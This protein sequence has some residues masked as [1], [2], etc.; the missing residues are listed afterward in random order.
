MLKKIRIENLALVET[1]QI[2]FD[3]GLTV[4]TGETGAGKSI[5]VNALSLALGGR[6]EREYIR[7]GA[8]RCRVEADFDVSSM[9]AEFRGKFA[10][11]INE[12]LL[13]ISREITGDGR[14]RIRISDSPATLGQLKS[15]TS[16]IAE[17]LG[18]H[19][20]QMLMNEDNHLLFLDHFAALARKKEI[21][22]GAYHDWLQTATRLS[23]ITARR[24]QLGAERELLLFQRNEIEKAQIHVG[25]EEQLLS[26]RKVLDS[27]RV[28]MASADMIRDIIENEENS[29]SSLLSLA[30]KELDRMARIDTQL[31]KKVAEL[32]EMTYQLEDLRAF[33]EQYGSSIG[34]D[35]GR[36]EEINLRLDEIYNLKKKYGGSEQSVLDSLEIINK[37]LSETPADID[38]YIDELANK[39]RAL[40]ELYSRHA[41]TLSHARKKAATHLQKLVT[42]ELED[43]AIENGGFEFE[44]VYED[45]P[46]G[47]VING[48]AVRPTPDGL[49]KGRIMF[50]A[51]PGEPLK[52]LV[53][54][55][56]G[57]EISRVLLALK[58]AEK[59]NHKLLHSLLVFDEVDSGIGGRTAMKVGKKLAR[60][61]ADSQ[62][63]VITHLHQIARE[64]THHLLAEKKTGS[65]KRSVISVRRLDSTG[66]KQEL[67]RMMALPE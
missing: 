35:P 66:I 42:R 65:D 21:V 12:G 28:L 54:T 5:I 30:Q 34:D 22:A 20:A 8:D 51:N 39:S 44:F 33:I 53:K 61:S 29:V 18:Q 3:K 14:S 43:L 63:I 32:I 60:L 52:S 10:G 25:E 16:P 2:E 41:L 17:I 4:L 57:G 27:A 56:S 7:D 11:F 49:E 48:R 37:K 50:S 9:P 6:A 1:A 55:A 26:E 40:F 19:A 59:K 64:G 46:E 47:V 36:I 13:R 38:D 67:A 23:E 24:D 45:D 58:S 31:E 62:L 15:V